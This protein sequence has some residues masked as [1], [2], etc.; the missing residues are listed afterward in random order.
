MRPSILLA[1]LALAACS[2]PTDRTAERQAVAAVSAAAPAGRW[3]T[4]DGAGEAALVFVPEDGR[5]IALICT[6]GVEATFRVETADESFRAVPNAAAAAILLGDVAIEGSLTQM[7]TE[8]GGLVQMRTPITE[9]LI[10]QLRAAE[11][12]R[13]NAGDAHVVTGAAPAAERDAFAAA[14]ASLAGLAGP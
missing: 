4:A 12:V 8:A 14:C 6:L 1:A 10:A 13:L 3:L 7:A 2:P 5:E 11:S 9:T